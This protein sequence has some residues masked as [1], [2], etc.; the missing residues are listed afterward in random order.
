MFR[1]FDVHE[2]NTD[3]PVRLA[4]SGR[5][6]RLR[7]CMAQVPC[8]RVGIRR[9]LWV[10]LCH[11]KSQTLNLT[12]L[13]ALGRLTIEFLDRLLISRLELNPQ[14]M[15]WGTPPYSWAYRWWITFYPISDELDYLPVLVS[16]PPQ[17]TIFEYLVGCWKRLNVV[18]STV[19]KKVKSFEEAEMRSFIFSPYLGIY[20]SRHT[21]CPWSLGEDTWITDQLYRAYF[22]RTWNVPS[23]VWVCFPYPVSM[24]SSLPDITQPSSR[25]IWASS[26]PSFSLLIIRSFALQQLGLAFPFGHWPF[27][28][29]SRPPFR[30][31]QR[32]G[33]NTRSCRSPFTISRVAFQAGRFGWRGC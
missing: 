16:L 31:W 4:T 19:I 23:T 6:K 1:F 17:Q 25:T 18:R 7:D 29:R 3:T 2:I 10:N 26:T 9:H 13:V 32:D 5:E 22:A 30:A 24:I 8:S 14:I 11:E 20:T 21:E 33:W 12:C 15:T 27:F 28:A